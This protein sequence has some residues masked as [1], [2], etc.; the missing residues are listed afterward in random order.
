MKTLFVYSTQKTIVPEKPL[1]GQ[2][3]IYHGVSSVAGTLHGHGHEC[4]LVVLDRTNGKKN[5]RL[6]N[7]KIRSFNPAIIAFTAVFSEFEFIRQTAEQVKTTYPNLFLIAGGVH[8]TLNPEEEYLSLFDAICI[9]EGEYPMLELVENLEQNK[10][11][12]S[13][14]NLWVRTPIFAPNDIEK[15][16]KKRSLKF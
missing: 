8:I 15:N 7:D 13:I 1:L 12:D 14:Q 4:D 9:G 5:L 6:L 10:P 16:K 2:E 11:V 3:G